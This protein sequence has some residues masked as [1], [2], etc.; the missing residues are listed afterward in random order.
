M[1]LF[2]FIGSL[3]TPELI[4]LP[5]LFAVAIYFY[6]SNGNSEASDSYVFIVSAYLLAMMTALALLKVV[7]IV[8]G[9]FNRKAGTQET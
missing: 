8:R 7:R 5:F 1:K 4:A 2:R 9:V 6:L 3:T